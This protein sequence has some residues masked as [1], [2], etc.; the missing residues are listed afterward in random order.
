LIPRTVPEIRRLVLA[1]AG[2]VEERDFLLGWSV[3]RRTHQ[4][5]AARCKKASRAARATL[6][7]ERLSEDHA[8]P[9]VTALLT[10]EGA[11]LTDTE[12]EYV[13]PLLPPRRGQVGRPLKDHRQ[14]L[15]GI[16]W[17]ARTGSSWRDMPEEYGDWSTAYHRWRAWK[18]RGLWQRILQALGDEELPGPVTKDAN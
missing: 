12:W 10:P 6:R 3:W 17:V 8:E 1:M 9:K 4:A 5:I 15:S 16:L 13:H 7:R 11:R 14:V 18:K 2:S